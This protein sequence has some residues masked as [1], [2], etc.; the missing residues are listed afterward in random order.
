LV[1]LKS[2]QMQMKFNALIASMLLITSAS[3][4]QTG[5]TYATGTHTAHTGTKAGFGIKGGVNFANTKSGGFGQ[6][7]TSI[8][9]LEPTGKIGYYGGIFY[10]MPLSGN[11]RLQPELLFST[12]GHSQDATDAGGTKKVNDL[13]LN[14]VQIPVMLQ[15]ASNKGFYVEAGP[16]IGFLTKAELTNDRQM[17]GASPVTNDLKDFTKSTAWALAAGLGYNFRG[18]FGIGARYVYGLTNVFEATAATDVNLAARNLTL[19][20]HF[21]F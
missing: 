13:D 9:Y 15:I 4:Q 16:Q 17:P 12:E 3:A 8:T 19:G 2:N 11:L 18:G 5:N 20:L 6:N 21:R 1:F 10:N 14:Y 7:S